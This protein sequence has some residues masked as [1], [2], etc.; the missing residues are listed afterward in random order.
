M[1]RFGRNEFLKSSR[2]M[3]C[4]LV[5]LDAEVVPHVFCGNVVHEQ[6]AVVCKEFVGAFFDV[7]VGNRG[8]NVVSA[9]SWMSGVAFTLK[10]LANFGCCYVS[11]ILFKKKAV[12]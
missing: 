8:H 1:G 12:L 5:D 6:T 9:H 2:E 10:F 7:V 3:R 11:S 4:L